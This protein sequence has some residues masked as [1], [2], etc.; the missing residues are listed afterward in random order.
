MTGIGEKLS[1]NVLWFT[2]GIIAA[3]VV[4]TVAGVEWLDKKI[5]DAIASRPLERTDIASITNLQRDLKDLETQYA[6]NVRQTQRHLASIEDAIKSLMVNTQQKII[7]PQLLTI[8]KATFSADLISKSDW[9]LKLLIHLK[10][11]CDGKERCDINTAGKT[12]SDIF[13]SFKEV[14]VAFF[15]GTDKGAPVTEQRGA[16]IILS[17]PQAN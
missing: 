12:V 4:G 6:V 3:A 2:L 15:C 14:S 13:S 10:E 7:S 16:I 17:C 1:G 11:K 8:T 9:D 5:A